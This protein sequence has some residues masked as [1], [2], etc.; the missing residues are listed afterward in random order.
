MMFQGE[1]SKAFPESV[2]APGPL[3][4]A[5]KGPKFMI[6]RLNQCGCRYG[7]GSVKQMTRVVES[8]M[9]AQIPLETFVTDSQYMDK[10]QDFTF[11]ADYAVDD[12]QVASQTQHKLLLPST[13]VCR[14]Y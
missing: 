12:F 8:Y 6:F 4:E 13:S 11:S 2:K 7:Y 9:Q 5:W 10:D 1:K 14:W 3:T